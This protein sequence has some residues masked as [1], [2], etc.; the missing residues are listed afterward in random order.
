MTIS[1]E[2]VGVVAGIPAIRLLM[3]ERYTRRNAKERRKSRFDH[4]MTE[5]MKKKYEWSVDL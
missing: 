2:A 3:E 5:M 4:A 1:P